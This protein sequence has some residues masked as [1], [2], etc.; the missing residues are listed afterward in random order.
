MQ[1]AFILEENGNVSL[2]RVFQT[3]RCTA[4]A[5]TSDGRVLE[6]DRF[7]ILPSNDDELLARRLDIIEA[8]GFQT[9]TLRRLRDAVAE[10]AWLHRYHIEVGAHL[11]D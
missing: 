11:E 2:A 4:V 10:P 1:L 5:L 9:E 3:P 8:D 7:Y 6:D